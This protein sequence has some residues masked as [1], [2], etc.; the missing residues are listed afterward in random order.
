MGERLKVRRWLLAVL[1]VAVVA[2]AAW[3]VSRVWAARGARQVQSQAEPFRIVRVERG[4]IRQTVTAIGN[5]EPATVVE[6]RTPRAGFVSRVPVREGQTVSVNQV[7]V[8]LEATDQA[9]KLKQA[10]ADLLSAR[11]NLDKL[12]AGPDPAELA[13]AESSVEQARLTLTDAERAHQR[14]LALAKVGGI[15]SQQVQESASKLEA[16]RLQLRTAEEKLRQLKSAPREPD[17]AVAKAKV[18]Q[19][20]AAVA[21]ARRELEASQIR[22]PIAGTV[23]TLEVQTGQ[24]ISNNAAVATVADLTRMKA[25]VP[26]NEMDVPLIQVGQRATVEL[27][28]LPGR[29]FNGRVVEVAQQGVVRDNIVSYEVVI[30]LRNEDGALKPG[31]TANATILVGEKQDVLVV[32]SEAV[33]ERGGTTMV[34]VPQDGQPRPVPIRTGLRTDTQ[35]EVLEGLTEGQRILIPTMA[36]GPGPGAGA[37]GNQMRMLV[38]PGGMTGRFIGGGAPRMN[39]RGGGR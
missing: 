7:L 11:A 24:A 15:A 28:A 36:A 19:A 16:A 33:V 8:E 4:Q 29:R 3:G 37:G 27:D 20:E 25:R 35:V 26:I 17:V 9:V 21:A 39:N 6:I 2:G 14:N 34:L 18:A 12:L 23:L 1:L 5:L 22:T 13:A 10:E 31:M 30:E 38:G 32:P